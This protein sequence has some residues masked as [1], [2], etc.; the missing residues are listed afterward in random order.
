MEYVG[1]L[2]EGEARSLLDRI[3]VDEMEAEPLTEDQIAFVRR[4]LRSLDEG[5]GV[6]HSEVR[7]MLGFPR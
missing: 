1:G 2:S 5:R 4:S 7:R 3:R 6:P